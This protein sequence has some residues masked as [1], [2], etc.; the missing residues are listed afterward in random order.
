MTT[1]DDVRWAAKVDEFEQIRSR[2]AASR[3]TLWV[4]AEAVHANADSLHTRTREVHARLVELRLA[5]AHAKASRSHA[6]EEGRL[7]IGSRDQVPPG[8]ARSPSRESATQER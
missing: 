2:L 4:E 7:C 1:R 8:S 3:R 6:G 5:A